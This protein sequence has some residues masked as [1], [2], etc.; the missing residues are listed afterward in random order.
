MRNVA[1]HKIP[2]NFFFY[3]NLQP[4]MQNKILPSFTS[5][6]T[7]LFIKK[8]NTCDLL[9]NFYIFNYFKLVFSFHVHNSVTTEIIFI[10]CFTVTMQDM[11]S[12]HFMQFQLPIKFEGD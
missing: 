11:K 9:R 3:A 10:V 12:R 4:Y 5:Y 6:S 7:Q 1:I 8:K 2:A